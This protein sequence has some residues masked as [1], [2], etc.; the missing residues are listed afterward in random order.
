MSLTSWK[1]IW[2]NEGFATYAEWLW[3]EQHGGQS[4]QT[5]F[6]GFYARPA[7]SS[8]WAFP[9]ADPGNGANI[10]A[11][12]VYT[13]G[14]MALH[15]LRTAVG[16]TAFFSI[17]KTWAKQHRYGNGT[18]AQFIELS[19]KRS[20]KDLGAAVPDLDLHRG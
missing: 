13:R 19:E 16:D 3:E 6:D 7:T 14:A 2:L 8:L 10:F 17:L 5:Q 20:G 11:S 15:K 9:S 12:P 4:A 18:T 1:D